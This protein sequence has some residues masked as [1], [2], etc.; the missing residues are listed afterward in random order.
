VINNRNHPDAQPG[1]QRRGPA[2]RPV[3]HSRS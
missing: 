3:R 1:L 2:I